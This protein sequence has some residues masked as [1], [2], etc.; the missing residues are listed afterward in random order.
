ARPRRRSHRATD[1]ASASKSY[2]ANGAKNDSD[3][4]HPRPR[5][6]LLVL[7]VAAPPHSGLVAALGGAVEPLI[8][9]PEPVEPARIGGIG[10]VDGAAL[11]HERAEAR[12]IAHERARIGAAHGRELRD[13]LRD[14]S[15]RIQ[16]M[17][18]ALVIVFG[19]ALALLLLGDRDVEVEVE[20]AAMRGR[21]GERPAHAPLISLEL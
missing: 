19:A 14:R 1:R 2:S 11:A 8:H 16:R 7:V 21:P 17:A 9:A 3:E 12:P 10:V 5:S 20:V 13:G 6:A 18:A 4:R 15:R